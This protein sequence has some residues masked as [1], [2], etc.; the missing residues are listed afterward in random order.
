MIRTRYVYK[1]RSGIT[2]SE[3]VCVHTFSHISTLPTCKMKLLTMLQQSFKTQNLRLASD[4]FIW[5][6]PASSYWLGRHFQFGFPWF[7]DHQK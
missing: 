7:E 1:I 5:K 6:S 2:K 3:H 4:F